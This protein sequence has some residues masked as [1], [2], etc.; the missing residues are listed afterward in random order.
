MSDRS[1]SKERPRFIKPWGYVGYQILFSIPV[2]GWI[3][4]IIFCFSKR[5]NRRY[6]ARAFWCWVLIGLILC[7]LMGLAGFIYFRYTNTGKDKATQIVDLW[8]ETKPK[9]I[10]IFTGSEDE[11]LTDD[12]DEGSLQ[13]TEGE[14]AEA[15]E[16]TDDE[17]IAA[18]PQELLGTWENEADGTSYQFS[19]NGKGYYT[20]DATET[21]FD[22]TA[23]D[24]ALTITYS[25]EV[26][27]NTLTY[28]I[29]GEVLT[30]TDAE[31]VTTTYTRK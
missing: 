14:D 27:A 3:I 18:I 12:Q 28:A 31:G 5:H 13:A 4:S 20:A 16:T 11:T 24:T 1:S 2:I 15:G 7:I 22:F 6:Y 9:V 25:E 23:T 8:N 19:V 21:A 17:A 10:R 26:E 29:D 30:L